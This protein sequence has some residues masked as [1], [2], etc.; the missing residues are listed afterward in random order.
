[1]RHEARLWIWENALEERRMDMKA[2]KCGL[3]CKGVCRKTCMFK[4]TEPEEPAFIF[5]V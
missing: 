3:P 4:E 5:W 2:R 1:M